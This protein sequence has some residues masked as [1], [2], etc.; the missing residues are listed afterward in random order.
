MNKFRIWI[1]RFFIAAYLL[2]ILGHCSGCG[3]PYT[4]KQRIAMGIYIGAAAADWYTT[5]RVL[6]DG[7]YECNPLMS[8][9]P[10]DGELALFNGIGFGI[11]W[12]AGEICPEHREAFWY[13]GAAIKGGVAVKNTK[14][15]E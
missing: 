4:S 3:V 15:I 2:V 13:I 9:H 6:D 8:K 14:Y 7:G 12:L 10:N 11:I 1:I 5:N